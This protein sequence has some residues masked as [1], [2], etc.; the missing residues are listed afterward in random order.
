MERHYPRVEG[1]SKG[2]VEEATAESVLNLKTA[3]IG[4][5]GLKLFNDPGWQPGWPQWKAARHRGLQPET[6]A[7]FILAFSIE[8]VKFKIKHPKSCPSLSV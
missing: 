8:S 1:E 3:R 4:G 6:L 2:I 5:C 7:G